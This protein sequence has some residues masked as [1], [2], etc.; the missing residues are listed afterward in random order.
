MFTRT[1]VSLLAVKASTAFSLEVSD[2]AFRGSRDVTISSFQLYPENI[3]FDPKYQRAYISAL[4][5]CSVAV[6]DPLQNRVVETIKFP[7][8]SGNPSF[9]ASGIQVDPLG[10]L[11]VIINAGVAFD[12]SGKNISGDNFLVKYDLKKKLLSFK[13]NLTAVTN[14]VYGGYQDVEHDSCGNSFVVGTFPSSIIRVSANG[15]PATPWFL[16]R[17]TNSTKKGLTGL[18][19]K[20][21]ILLASDEEGG[22]L[23]RF[24]MRAAQGVPIVVQIG[25]NG[26]NSSS[27]GQSLD[28]I[29]LPARFGG[30]ILLVS[31]NG[32][33]T[34]VLRSRD[35]AWRSAEKLG[36]IPNPFLQQGGST[37]ASVQMGEKIYSL[38]EFFAD[39]SSKIPGTLAGNRTEFPLHDITSAVEKLL[40]Q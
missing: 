7:G 15:Q 40:N 13:S 5:N 34:V 18:A 37:T 22:R 28:G 19:A 24:D 35:G 21:S 12:T 27:I 6:Y 39:T 2:Y 11:S 32:A 14:G 33:G 26:Q 9:H 30:K 17:N 16:S 20:G 10:R 23:L 3:D 31:A 29:Y 4:Y 38:T 36:V 1:L 25:N 8:L